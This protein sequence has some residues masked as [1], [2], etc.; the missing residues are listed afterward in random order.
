MNALLPTSPMIRP[1]GVGDAAIFFPS[2]LNDNVVG[3]A[4]C[5]YVYVYSRYKYKSIHQYNINILDD[6][7]FDERGL[8]LR[9]PPRPS[10]GHWLTRVRKR[11]ETIENLML[12]RKKNTNTVPMVTKNC[13]WSPP[14]LP[15]LLG[16][17]RS[18]RTGKER[19]ERTIAKNFSFLKCPRDG[20]FQDSFVEITHS[21]SPW[22]C[23]ATP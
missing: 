4:S 23:P 8:L 9:L 14:D 17:S 5:L 13:S 6:C 16:R 15:V 12:R 2:S 10:S 1:D 20:H 22:P 11:S 7:A 21:E 19:S 18:H 3:R